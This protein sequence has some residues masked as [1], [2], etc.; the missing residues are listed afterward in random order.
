MLNDLLFGEGLSRVLNRTE[1]AS[2]HV[3]LAV[4]SEWDTQ[5]YWLI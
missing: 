1:D 3:G 5:D 4:L 2:V